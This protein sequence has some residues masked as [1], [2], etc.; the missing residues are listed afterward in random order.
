MLSN[1][2]RISLGY[3]EPYRNF[4][5]IDDLLDAWCSVINSPAKVNNGYIFTIGPDDPIKIKDYV[6]MI[7]DKINWQGK[8]LWDT[9][10]ERPGEIYWLNSNH[11]LITSITGW[12][13]KVSLSDGID[14][15]IDV[16]QDILTESNKKIFNIR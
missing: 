11:R 5:F 4:I 14:Y 6:S 15:T 3:G 16:W 13:P 10:P 7:A 8:V 9:K 1:P 2:E 12:E